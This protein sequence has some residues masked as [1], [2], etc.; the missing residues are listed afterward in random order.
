MAKRRLY[1]LAKERGLQSSELLEALAGAGVEG[2]SALST[3]EEAELDDLL[4]SANGA[5]GSKAATGRAPSATTNGAGPAGAGPLSLGERIRLMR[6][7]RQL[8]KLHRAQLEELAGLAIELYR[9]DSPRKEDLADERLQAAAETDSELI[10]IEKRLGSSEVGGE[11]PKCGLHSSRT[12]YCLRCGEKLPTPH[13]Q[14][15]SA[16]GGAVAVI[17]I[18]LA[19]LLGGV[20]LG[21]QSTQNASAPAGARVAAKKSSGPQFRSVVAKVKGPRIGVY[22]SPNDPQPFARLSNPNGDGAPLVFLVKDKHF[23]GNWVHVYLPTRPNGSTGWVRLSKVTL[24][25]DNFHGKI[26]LTTHRLTVWQGRDRFLKT[27]VGVGR[28]VTPT[29]PGL[30]YV[31][32]L[33]KPTNPNGLYGPYA[34]GLSV[35]SNVL[36]E[37]A[38]GDGV[39]GMHGT[40]YPQGIG[41]NVSHGCIRMSNDA[42][43]KLAHSLPVG[44]PVRIVGRV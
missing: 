11:C 39:L 37:F 9:L 34:F 7:R 4:K 29:P 6:R 3:M 26:N 28:T 20:N 27:P 43:I 1:E 36:H 40:N 2:K 10:Q 38:G 16:T 44:T 24:S 12:R 35:H 17:V 8:R 33:L 25:G 42:V 23:Q 31:T 15:L 5:K 41:T 32:E 21:S 13:S 22:S 18:A 14:A 30:Y 19:W